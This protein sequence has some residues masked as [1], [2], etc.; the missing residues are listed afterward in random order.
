MLR[1]ANIEDGISQS[2]LSVGLE[3]IM[4]VNSRANGWVA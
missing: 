1:V 3:Y 4:E 2:T